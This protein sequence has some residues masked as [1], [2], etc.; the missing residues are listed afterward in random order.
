MLVDSI[1]YLCAQKAEVLDIMQTSTSKSCAQEHLLILLV[2]LAQ[3]GA[4]WFTING[5]T[6]NECS[7]CRRLGF[8]N[9]TDYYAFLVHGG[10]AGYE[11]NKK[12]ARMTSRST[13]MLGTKC[14]VVTL[15]TKSSLN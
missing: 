4:S 3:Y 2:F 6:S 8:C 13:R 7:L 5:D 9:E 10:L 1:I 12:Q 15:I 11:N 14:S